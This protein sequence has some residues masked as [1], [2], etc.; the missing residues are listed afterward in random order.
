[1]SLMPF[2]AIAF[3]RRALTYCHS[4]SYALPFN[5]TASSEPEIVTWGVKRKRCRVPDLN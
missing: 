4:V 1:M 2:S 5:E 3:T